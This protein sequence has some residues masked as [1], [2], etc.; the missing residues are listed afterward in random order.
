MFR[1]THLSNKNDQDGKLM[2]IISP[3]TNQPFLI[4]FDMCV[5]HGVASEKAMF[6]TPMYIS[7]CFG[8]SPLTIQKGGNITLHKGNPVL[9]HL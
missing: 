4:I 8:P 7:P 5:S 9:N 6:V 2:E 1:Q 3:S